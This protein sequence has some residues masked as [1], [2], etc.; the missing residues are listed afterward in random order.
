MKTDWIKTVQLEGKE[1]VM[2]IGDGNIY[3]Y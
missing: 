1:G 2:M 3:Y